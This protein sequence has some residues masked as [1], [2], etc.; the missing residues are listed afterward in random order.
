MFID[1]NG[2]Y[3]Y[4][5]D[6][7]NGEKYRYY[8]GATQKQV[9]GEWVSAKNDH[10]SDFVVATITGLREL[11]NRSDTGKGLIDKFS[12]DKKDVTFQYREVNASKGLGNEADWKTNTI[13]FDHNFDQKS[14]TSS[15]YMSN[16]HFITIGHEMSHLTDPV[17]YHSPWYNSK[18]SEGE[19]RATH[20]ENIIRAESGLPLRTHYGSYKIGNDI[21]PDARSTIVD[22]SGNSVYYNTATQRYPGQVTPTLINDGIKAHNGVILKSRLNYLEYAKR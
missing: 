8:N 18:V 12:G 19:I 5:N 3:I 1:V 17:K 2:E 11:G 15:G 4:I 7:N 22:K 21:L 13:F 9:D 10:L 14:H 16:E 20:Y 6:P